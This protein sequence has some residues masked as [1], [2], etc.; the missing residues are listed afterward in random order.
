VSLDFCPNGNQFASG[1][2]DGT[3]S[4]F[5]MTQKV[6]TKKT[7]NDEANVKDEL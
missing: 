2:S 4:I 6:S 1:S 7:E 3:V 5:S